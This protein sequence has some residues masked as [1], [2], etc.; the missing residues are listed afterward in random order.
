MEGRRRKLIKC[1]PERFKKPEQ[2]STFLKDEERKKDEA[3]AE[4][5]ASLVCCVILAA[6]SFVWRKYS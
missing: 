3:F 2:L 4:A 5:V 1:S 6:L